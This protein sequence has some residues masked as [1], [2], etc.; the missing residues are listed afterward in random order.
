MPNKT[1]GH[2]G[3]QEGSGQV[4]KIRRRSYLAAVEARRI[5]QRLDPP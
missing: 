5:P 2:Q 3:T 1:R 4:I